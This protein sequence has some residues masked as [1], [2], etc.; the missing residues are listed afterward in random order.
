MIYCYDV[1]MCNVCNLLD[2][3]YLMGNNDSFI[4]II[5]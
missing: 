4:Y 2:C 3:I 1:S 5:N